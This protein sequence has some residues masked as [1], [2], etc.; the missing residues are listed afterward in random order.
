MGFSRALLDELR[1]LDG[2][3]GARSIL[4]RHR[5][6]LATIVVDDRGIFADIDT[7]AE[8]AAREAARDRG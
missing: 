2:D 4:E 6:T 7:I 1:A 3:E 8:L 5:A